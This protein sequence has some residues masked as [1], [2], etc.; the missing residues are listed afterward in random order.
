MKCDG[1]TTTTARD[2]LQTPE[3]IHS[4]KVIWTAGA[5][6]SDAIKR[7]VIPEQ[8]AVF[9]QSGMEEEWAV[10]YSG[11]LIQTRS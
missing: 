10:C 5:Q 2:N 4:H 1:V 7:A 11:R 6:R 9:F 3:I 8:P